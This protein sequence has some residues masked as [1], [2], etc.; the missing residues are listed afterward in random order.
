MTI[1]ARHLSHREAAFVGQYIKDLRVGAAAE[2]AGLSASIGSKMIAM[3][4]VEEAICQALKVRQDFNGIDAQ[5]VLM[6]LVDNHYLA[7]QDSNLSASNQALGIL[8]K[9][10]SI[11]AMAASRVLLVGEDELTRRLNASRAAMAGDGDSD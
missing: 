2:R 10:S 1:D 11:D 4:H 8:A 5:W 3:Q 9:H 6:E 7:R